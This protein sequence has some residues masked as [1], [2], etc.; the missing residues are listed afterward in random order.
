MVVNKGK[1]IKWVPS[2]LFRNFDELAFVLQLFFFVDVHGDVHFYV[3]KTVLIVS[4]KTVSTLSILKICGLYFSFIHMCFNSQY[5]GSWSLP[6]F[7]IIDFFFHQQ[8]GTE[9]DPLVSRT[10]K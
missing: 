4:P 5:Y 8:D 2:V 3:F 7:R 10:S 6:C 9:F 1:S